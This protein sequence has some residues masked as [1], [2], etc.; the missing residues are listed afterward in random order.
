LVSKHK[1]KIRKPE[2]EQ[3]EKKIED[4]VL[5][6]WNKYILTSRNERKKEI[7]K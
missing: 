1:K 5:H 2:E 4:N 6:G 7:K 3:E